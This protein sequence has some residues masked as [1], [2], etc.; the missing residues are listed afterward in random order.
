MAAIH[1]IIKLS[2][3]ALQTQHYHYTLVFRLVWAM[4]CAFHEMARKRI[5][6]DKR[7]TAHFGSGA[8]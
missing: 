1:V 2:T 4:C 7:I 8:E 6:W 3:K 5:N